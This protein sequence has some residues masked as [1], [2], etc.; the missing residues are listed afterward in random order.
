VLHRYGPLGIG[1]SSSSGRVNAVVERAEM[2]VPVA[3][4]WIAAALLS[5]VAA[6][7]YQVL[8]TRRASLL[9][10]TTVMAVSTVVSTFLAGLAIG[11]GVA[12]RALDRLPR[13]RLPGLYAGLEWGTAAL[14]ALF[15]MALGSHAGW[16]AMLYRH[17]VSLGWM[18]AARFAICVACILPPTILMGATLP[19]LVALTDPSPLSAGKV[20]GRL[21]AWNTLG[22][23]LGALGAVATLPGLGL[24]GTSLFAQALNVIAGG[25]GVSFSG[26]RRAPRPIEAA[27]L[28]WGG[29]EVI[30]RAVVLL[31]IALSGLGALADEVAWTRS[32]VLLIGPTVYSVS[33][34]VAAVIA[35][36]A[37]G[38]ATL[39]SLTNRL[40]SPVS[41]LAVVE[42]GAAFSSILVALILGKLPST[43]GG[44]VR[45]NADR[46][47]RLLG[48]ELLGIFLLLLM[49]S[50][51]FGAAFP[52]AVRLCSG[53]GTTPCRGV[54][55][56]LA[57]NTAG[58]IAGALLAGFVALS[59]LGLER[60]LYAAAAV[61]AVAGAIL[62]RSA[63]PKGWALAALVLLAAASPLC[64]GPWWDRELLASGVYKYAPYASSGTM[65][66][67]LRRG[68][69]VYYREGPTATVSVRRVGTTLSL[70]IDGKVDATNAADMPTQRLLAHL[71]LLLHSAPHRVCLV[72]LGSGATAA[73]ALTHPIDS[74][75]VIEISPE[76]VEAASLFGDFPK[77]ADPRMRLRIADGRNHLLLTD[78]RYD[79]IISEPSNPWMAGVSNLFTRDFFHLAQGRLSTGG[80]FCQWAHLYNMEPNDLRT[81]I[82]GFSDVF[83]RAMLFLVSEADILLLG[84]DGILPNAVQLGERM[85]QES[86]KADLAQMGVVD[87]YALASLYALGSPA[88]SLWVG[89][90]DRHTDDRPILEFRAPWSIHAATGPKNRAMILEAA[91]G[92]S[93][94]EPFDSVRREPTAEGLLGRARM[95]E[96]AE[97]FEWAQ[98][99]YREAARLRAHLLP[100]YEGIVRSALASGRG[101]EAEDDL[102]QLKQGSPEEAGFGLALLYRNLDRAPEALAEVDGVLRKH[103]QNVRAMLLAAEVQEEMGNIDGVE[104]LS[105]RA[106]LAHPGDGEAEAFLATVCL[107]RGQLTEAVSRAESVLSGHPGVTRALEAKAIALAQLGDKPAARKAF[108]ALLEAGP[109][110]WVHFNNYGL[111]EMEAGNYGV[112]ATLFEQAVDINP[113]NV[114]G[115]RGLQ[116]AARALGDQ[117][118][119][120]RAESMLNF[121]SAR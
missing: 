89:G 60:T 44:L 20:A 72:G 69:L 109:N 24:G 80:I 65:I 36:I 120:E 91:R 82:A 46:M 58:A 6:L 99:L 75:D 101:R 12:S 108:E 114:T 107:H 22:A 100:A 32:L 31:V 113:Q 66:D 90:S 96:V 35:G 94:P 81:L 38:S 110:G 19:T 57:W 78:R 77:L 62:L 3:S 67:A 88:L 41:A 7:V 15:P 26:A 98:E 45:D 33:F 39:S 83:P 119:R 86:V 29:P 18:T 102:R 70:A 47:S 116:E 115:Y 28:K 106:L 11:S 4:R 16:L 55:R 64:L 84:I 42:V 9:L 49:P 50:A 21:Y 112:A 13:R 92:V 5:G 85:R 74:L 79:V 103:P 73:S 117:A 56:V 25:L 97:S 30:P 71:P 37:L 87:P 61:H 76:V 93:V 2:R 40:P 52:L 118:R 17:D 95:L 1:A 63:T 8:W 59:I 10:G 14:A 105:E 48:L 43:V 54:G 27:P 34:I 51:L 53:S 121:L 111:F 68:R 23:V 104:R